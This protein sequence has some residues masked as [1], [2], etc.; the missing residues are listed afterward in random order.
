MALNIVTQE[1]SEYRHVLTT[2]AESVTFPLSSDDK[3]LITAM[4]VKLMALG[5]VGLAAPQVN[6]S[7][8][9]I[10]IYIPEDARLL[11]DHVERDYP[12]HILINPSYEPVAQAGRHFD[13]EACYSVSSKAGKVPRYQEIKLSYHNEA[14]QYKEQRESGF[15]ARVLQHEIDHINGLLIVD[16]LTPDCVQGSLEEMMA[17]RRAELPSDKKILFDETMAKKQKK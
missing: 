12:M 4:K 5:G 9:I 11:R 8:R 7:K 17:L 14:G 15:Y 13:F 10:A 6:V 2:P 3:K 16:R 1:Q